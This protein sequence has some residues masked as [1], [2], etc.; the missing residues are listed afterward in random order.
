[1]ILSSNV[2]LKYVIAK[3]RRKHI[4]ERLFL[5]CR[6]ILIRKVW[7]KISQFW[8]NRKNI[9][10]KNRKLWVKTPMLKNLKIIDRKL[11]AQSN[12]SAQKVSWRR[13]PMRMREM[14]KRIPTDWFSCPKICWRPSC[15]VD[16]WKSL[17]MANIWKEKGGV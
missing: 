12:L 15:Q 17:Q 4:L 2:W 5:L 14:K 6:I 13:K 1:M 8:I 16:F 11:F 3:K 9:S 10:K 7:K